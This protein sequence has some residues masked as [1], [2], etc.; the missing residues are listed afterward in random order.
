MSGECEEC[1]EKQLTINRYSTGRRPPTDLLPPRAELARSTSLSDSGAAARY[2]AGHNFGRL[3]VGAAALSGTSGERAVSQPGDRSEVEADRAAE[4]VMRALSSPVFEEKQEAP[5][6][7]QTPPLI[8]RAAA[9]ENT[10]EM[11]AEAE[12]T[13]ATE[14]AASAE[15]AAT[16]LIVEDDA[17]EVG[18]DQMRKSEFLDELRAAVCAAADAELA[19]AGRSTEGCPYIEQAFERYRNFSGSQLERGL[20]RYAPEAAGATSARDYISAATERV[21]QAVAVWVSTGRITGVPEG[22]T[23]APPEEGSSAAG[24]ASSS[25]K[26]VQ[27]KRRGGGASEAGNP[28]AIQ[29][30]LGSGRPLDGGVKSRMESAFGYDFS[31]VRIHTD[32]KAAELSSG[33]SAR[34]FTIGSDVAFAGGEYRPGTL[35]GDAL[36]AHEL[37]HVAQQG[38]ATT[39][40]PK[41]EAENSTLE[42]D[43][44]V[45]AVGAVLSLWGKAKGGLANISKSAMPRLRSGLRLSRC[46]CSTLGGQEW[47]PFC[48]TGDATYKGKVEGQLNTLNGTAQGKGVFG[49]LETKKGKGEIGIEYLSGVVGFL[50]DKIRYDPGASAPKDHCPTPTG[51]EASPIHVFL[52]HEVS[53]AYIYYVKNLGTDPDRE[54]MAAGLGKYFTDIAYNENKLRC[55]LKLPIRPCY[56]GMCTKFPPPTCGT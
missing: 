39:L 18:P 32:A 19:A 55:E 45:S 46:S 43:A 9:D 10:S 29:A 17:Q 30:R 51:W 40:M 8:Q 4:R 34:A 42:E 2:G 23:T 28:A 7:S 56:D 16:V 21:R 44:D 15:T 1:Q 25:S 5:A 24:A 27:F 54:C 11:G 52:F 22:A 31:R 33:L 12:E 35:I 26:G 50:P 20:R 14:T 13:P 38:G 41:G 47:G 53:H 3:R 36:I 6:L 37:A 48:I 49:D